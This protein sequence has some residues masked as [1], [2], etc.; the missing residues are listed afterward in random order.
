MLVNIKDC[1]YSVPQSRLIAMQSSASVAFIVPW[2]HLYEI[3]TLQIRNETDNS[4]ESRIYLG[5]NN[6]NAKGSTNGQ[7]DSNSMTA[8]TGPAG[9]GYINAAEGMGLGPWVYGDH[10]VIIHKKS[11]SNSAIYF[12]AGSANSDYIGIDKNNPLYLTPGMTLK[13]YAQNDNYLH[14]LISFI[15]HWG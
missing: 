8:M 7:Y 1:E 6:S 13:A 4:T 10:D 14:L 9:T 5:M 3:Q 15:D 12:G 11:M 2:G